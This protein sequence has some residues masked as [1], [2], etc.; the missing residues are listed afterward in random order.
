MS[1]TTCAIILNT[2]AGKLKVTPGLHEIESLAKAIGLDATFYYS[3]S[4]KEMQ[5][6][7]RKLVKKGVKKIV[8]AGGDGTVRL[9]VQEL[10]GSDS[11]LGIIPQGTFNNFATALHLPQDLPSA[12]RAIK[13][14]KIRQVSVGEIDGQYFTEAA[15]VGLFADI[16]A[17]YGAGTNKNFFK[18][19]YAMLR[20]LIFMSRR[21][22]RIT[23]DG[24]TIIER[25]VMCTAANTF[26]I[27]QG[28][29]IAPNASLTDNY[30]DVVVIGDL[31]RREF[32]MYYRAIQS[33]VHENLPKVTIYRAKE[34]HIETLTPLNVH[35][36]DQ[37]IG[38]T[39][40]TAII[41]PKAL[42]VLVYTI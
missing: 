3:D 15:G 24:Q 27:G 38:T 32:L 16:L 28:W 36:D 18:G 31:R 33:Q 12:L 17:L 19:L 20:T 39:P 9:A 30:L 22:L 7:V 6:M 34:V 35:G 4:S 41:R 13:D 23:L 25:A 14:G 1:A 40:T 2:H 26:R 29:P 11:V 8:V 42:N 10:V 21:R 37:V 5:K